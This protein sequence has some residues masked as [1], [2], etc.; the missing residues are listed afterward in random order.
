[1]RREPPLLKLLPRQRGMKEAR[2]AHLMCGDVFAN[3]E[4]LEAAPE[5]LTTTTAHPASRSS[6]TTGPVKQLEEQISAL[7]EEVAAL[8]QQFAEFRKQ[9]E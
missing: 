1:M 9:F 3:K 5:P 8:R 6:E 7:R 4:N 2:Y